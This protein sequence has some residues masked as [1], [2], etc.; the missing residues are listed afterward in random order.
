M[1]GYSNYFEIHHIKPIEEFK[2]TTKIVEVN[3]LNNLIALCPNH[4]WEADNDIL[5]EKYLKEKVG[6]GGLEPPTGKL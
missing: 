1:C 5:K 4:H 2:L 3:S 6:A